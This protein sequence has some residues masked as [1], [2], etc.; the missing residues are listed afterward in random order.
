MRTR[1]I[2]PATLLLRPAFHWISYHLVGWLTPP[3]AQQIPA[4]KLVQ[5]GGRCAY[6]L[7][8]LLG[9]C[10]R[11]GSHALL[12]IGKT[13]VAIWRADLGAYSHPLKQSGRKQFANE[14]QQKPSPASPANSLAAFPLLSCELKT[15]P[16]GVKPNV[17]TCGPG[18]YSQSDLL[19]CISTFLREQHKT[20]SI[21]IRTHTQPLC[22]HST[23]NHM[24]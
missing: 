14:R 17:P 16:N 5:T 24:H 3:I 13:N 23:T 12:K 18:S 20:R 15:S 21:S 4:T 19:D 7:K 10:L 1:I 11:H 22:C 9:G 6:G 8:P 2:E